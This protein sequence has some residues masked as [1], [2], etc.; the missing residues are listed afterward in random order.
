MRNN[1]NTVRFRIALAIVLVV[2]IVVALAVPFDKGTTFWVCFLFTIIAICA[3]LY[4]FRI[5]FR[6]GESVRSKFYGFPIARIG[7]IYL[8]VQ[9]IV[10][11]VLMALGTYVPAWVSVVICVVILG[12]SAVGFLSADAVRDE[13]ERQDVKLKTNVSVMRGLQSKISAVAGQAA[14]TANAKALK[15]LAEEFRYSDPVS[16]DALEEIEAE[17]SN[18]VDLL[19]QAV[20]DGDEESV[21]TLAQKTGLTL[22]ER[23]RLCKLSK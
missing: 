16:A 21:R 9:F 6:K 12:V 20:L 15:D 11:L 19:T 1:N 22:A 3:Q 17:L 8:V 2:Y 23:N 10:G 18:Q 5:A 13:V 14:D 4:I 7:I